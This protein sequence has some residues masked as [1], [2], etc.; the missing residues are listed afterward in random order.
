M[1]AQHEQ[2]P[3]GHPL[4]SQPEEVDEAQKE[5]T[6]EHKREGG[7]AREPYGGTDADPDE[8]WE[9]ATNAS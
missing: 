1:G 6:E 9:R 5:A 7:E 2:R 8:A 3:G 4:E